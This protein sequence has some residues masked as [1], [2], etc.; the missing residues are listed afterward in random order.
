LKT[1]DIGIQAIEKECPIAKEIL[2]FFSFLGQASI[3]ISLL[4]EWGKQ[5]RAE[6]SSLDLE[7][8]LRYLCDYSMI[9]SAHA[10]TY[11]V[12]LLV[13]T[14][15]RYQMGVTNIPMWP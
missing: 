6:V 15:T 3:P 9:G 4:E 8:A 12:H 7:N 5:S 10:H 1:W 13:Q 14:V 2:E 11:S